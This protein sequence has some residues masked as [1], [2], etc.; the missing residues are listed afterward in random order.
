MRAAS[1][2]AGVCKR[3]GQ[4]YEREED[5]KAA[6]RWLMRKVIPMKEAVR[7]VREGCHAT[8]PVYSPDGRRRKDR[9]DWRARH[10]FIKMAIEQAAYADPQPEANSASFINV[11]VKHLG[12]GHATEAQAAEATR[13]KHLA[14]AQADGTPRPN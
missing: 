6:Y 12:A 4:K 14:P 5:V 7:L 10:P 2:A 1:A 3:Q 11:V 9:P 8:M 13:P